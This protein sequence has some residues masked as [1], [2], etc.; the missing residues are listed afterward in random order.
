VCC[1]NAPLPVISFTF[2]QVEISL[3]GPFASD[4]AQLKMVVALRDTFSN[5]VVA[6]I[7]DF[8]DDKGNV[9][10]S[11]ADVIFST[12]CQFGFTSCV[13]VAESRD[14]YDIFLT[15][16][17][18]LL[19]SLDD[20]PLQATAIFKFSKQPSFQGNCFSQQLREFAETVDWL[21]KLDAWLFKLRTSMQVIYFFG[22]PLDF[23]LR[24]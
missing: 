13:Y 6:K 9:A 7:V 5:F 14:S 17:D 22:T 24:N 4:G 8:D 19:A 18:A 15:H 23:I 10:K 20:I 11:A 2:R 12:L 1:G 16:I 3:Q 21:S